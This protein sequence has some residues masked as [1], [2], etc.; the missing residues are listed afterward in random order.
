MAIEKFR[1]RVNDDVRAMLD[2]AEIHRA[3]KR[4]VDDERDAR[5]LR[6]LAHRP[7][8]EDATRRIHWRLEEDRAR[9]LA[10]LPPPDTR[11]GRVQHRDVDAERRELLHK[12]TLRATVDPRAGEQVIAR[13]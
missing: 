7:Q 6:E 11:L 12:E 10:H 4:R 1:R 13:S 3:R 9:L 8:I 2:G 5:F